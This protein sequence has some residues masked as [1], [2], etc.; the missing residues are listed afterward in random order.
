M[1]VFDSYIRNEV[2]VRLYGHMVIEI[3]YKMQSEDTE[4]RG[5]C[6]MLTYF[7]AELDTMTNKNFLYTM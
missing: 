6:A 5:H 1:R 4:K 2:C 3:K 7:K